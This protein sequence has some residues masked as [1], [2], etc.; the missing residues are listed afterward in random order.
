VKYILTLLL[1][2]LAV[3][4]KAQDTT[5]TYFDSAWKKT[6][7]EDAR[8]YMWVE[9]RD[10]FFA[11]QTFLVSNDCMLSQFFIKDTVTHRLVGSSVAYY[12]NGNIE[13]SNVYHPLRKNYTSYN[14]YE[15]GKIKDSTWFDSNGVIRYKYHFYPNGKLYYHGYYNDPTGTVLYQGYDTSGNSLPDFAYERDAS[16]PGGQEAWAKY[17]TKNVRTDFPNKVL[18][19]TVQIVRVDVKF[20]IGKDGT[21]YSPVIITSSGIKEVDDDAI[22]VIKN[23]PKWN[24]AIQQSNP[25]ATARIQPINYQLPAR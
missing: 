19:N 7:K 4:V 5:V 11:C 12:E 3:G 10:T 23:S 16:F 15:D 9:K 21:V 8:Y 18:R 24:W 20:N 13:D 6:V 22:K 17:I 2:A 25:V 1:I 14:F